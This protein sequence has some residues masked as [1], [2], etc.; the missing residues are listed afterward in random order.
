VQVVCAGGDGD[1][2]GDVDDGAPQGSDGV[3]TFIDTRDVAE[4][5]AVLFDI[6]A[7]L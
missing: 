2:G 4:V 5:F 3:C 6:Y 1:A 7:L